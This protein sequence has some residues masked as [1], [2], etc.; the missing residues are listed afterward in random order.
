MKTITGIDPGWS[1]GVAQIGPC[2]IKVQGFCNM[3]EK[4]IYET[5]KEYCR[6]SDACYIEKVHSMPRQGVASTFKFGLICGFLRGT[7]MSL[8]VPLH[9]VT[10]Q[11]WQKYLGC[12][13][14]GDKNVTKSMAQ[15]LYPGVKIT[16]ATADALLIAR[17]GTEQSTE[18]NDNEEMPLR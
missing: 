17:Y 5:V 1:G 11:R 6:F 15:R 16:H 7:V 12:L 2:T 4:D 18:R 9:E 13:S 10:P 3:T 8:E 14:K